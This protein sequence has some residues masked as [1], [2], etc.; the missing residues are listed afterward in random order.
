MTQEITFVEMR[1]AGVCGVIVWCRDHP[2]SHS[3]QL[4]LIVGLTMSGSQNRG[5]F[6]CTACGKRGADVRPGFDW[7]WVSFCQMGYRELWRTKP[8]GAI[9]AGGGK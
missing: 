2:C 3:V 1:S 9:F 5:G 4:V 8:L 7:N 6:S